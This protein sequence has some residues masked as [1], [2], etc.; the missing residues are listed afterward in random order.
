MTDNRRQQTPLGNLLVSV[1]NFM[2][3]LTH[4]RAG[5]IEPPSER[6]DPISVSE[7]LEEVRQPAMDI[8]VWLEAHRLEEYGAELDDAVASMFEIAVAFDEGSLAPV[9]S[10]QS[11]EPDTPFDQLLSG[12]ELALGRIEDLMDEIPDSVWAEFGE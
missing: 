11:D 12:I 8:V 1:R 7:A 3:L 4:S 6:D 10:G 5:V 2:D 9:F